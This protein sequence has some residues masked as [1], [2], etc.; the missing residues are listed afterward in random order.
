MHW[1]IIKKKEIDSW[2]EKLK[3]TNATLFQYPYYLTGEYSSLF[4]KSL[5]IKYV[6]DNGTELA[7]AAI[8][9][10]GVF[11]FK[12]GVI[13]D[14]PIVLQESFDLQIMLEDL[15]QF[16][17]KQF[18]MHLQIRPDNNEFE[19]LLKNDVLFNKEVFFPYHQ[20]E[21]SDWNIYNQPEEQ[22]LASFKRQCRRKIV[23]AG[24]V[25]F[26]FVKIEDTADL[27]D[28][29]ILFNQVTKIKG[30]RY[31]AFPALLKIY[32]NGKKY[33]LCDL[34]AVYLND[35]LVNAVFII[36]D[37]RCFY[38]FTSAMLVKGYKDNESPPAKLH[39]FI[40]QDCFYNE[41]KSFY[42]ISYGGTDNLVRFKELFNP[43]EIK[44]PPYY[45][46]IINKKALSIFQKTTPEGIGRIRTAFRKINKHMSSVYQ[47]IFPLVFCTS[48][49][50]I[51]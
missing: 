32:K 50:S 17:K 40:M 12:V 7:F 6:D 42:N 5:F 2:N 16:S 10:I 34:Y 47:I 41:H 13:D 11:P 22:L 48:L 36:K 27:K 18:Y 38:H 21:K 4:Y 1:E 46:Y 29:R 20:K 45:T 19:N 44:K 8:I 25:P 9:E 49:L 43:V 30:H 35:E 37:A 3:Q 23:L 51:E 24:R 33:N 15:K 28:V 39:L 26:K 31:I 14:G